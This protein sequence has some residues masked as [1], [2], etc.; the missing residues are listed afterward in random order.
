MRKKKSSQL[1]K[2]QFK[3]NRAAYLMILVPLFVYFAFKYVPMFG[4][5]IAFQ[6]FDPWSGFWNSPWVGLK[7][8]EFFIT[9][10]YFARIMINTILLNALGLLFGFPA[11]IIYALLLNEIRVGKF[12]KATQSISYL[13]HFISTVVIVGIMMKMFGYSGVI[14]KFIVQFGGEAKPFFSLSQ[15]FRPMYVG[16]SIWQGLGWGSIVYLASIAGIN[17]ELYEAAVIDGAN[18]FQQVMRITLPSILPTIM[19]LFILQVGQI[20]DVGFEKVFLMYNPATYETADVISTFVYRRGI[21]NLQYSY[22][23][24]VGLFRAVLSFILLVGANR[25][26]KTLTQSSLW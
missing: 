18:R 10:P 2:Y 5:L 6:D 16:S 13:P 15:A 8:F 20:L 12:K 14:N 1:L 7:H 4:I 24:A 3:H 21:E 26:S 23:T 9:G 17:L 19:I 25:L 11:P 22:G